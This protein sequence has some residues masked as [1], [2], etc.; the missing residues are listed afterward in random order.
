MSRNYSDY[1]KNK[2]VCCIPGPQGYRGDIGPTGVYGPSGSTGYTGMTGPTGMSG[3]GVPFGGLSPSPS[4]N[5]VWYD[6]TTNIMY[7]AAAKSFVIDHPLNNDKHLVHA[8]LEG[9]EAGV[10]YRG[11]GEI[12]DN[13]ST[14]INLPYYVEVLAT[15]FTIQIT[16]IYNG[17]INTLN[18]SEVISNKF[19]VYG[20]NCNFYWNV[21][22]K[23]NDIN[24]EPLK[25]SVNV[26]GDGPYL[27]I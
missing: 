22:G 27:Y 18:T 26:R 20:E 6:S 16:P 8:C 24:I 17:K 9:P 7:Y 5:G 23:R 10:Y 3:P 15:D 19:T 1:L 2:N 14:T 4:I 21:T 25:T 13:Q 11:V 12:L